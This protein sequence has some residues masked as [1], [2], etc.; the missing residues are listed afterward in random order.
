MARG[1]KAVSANTD[2]FSVVMDEQ[3]TQIERISVVLRCSIHKA[4]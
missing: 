4:V 3:A 2:E 1:N